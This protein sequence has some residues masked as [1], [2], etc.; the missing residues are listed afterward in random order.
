MS[1]EPVNPYKTVGRFSIKP[2][3][4][5]LTEKRQV[6]VESIGLALVGASAIAFL[7][8]R[9]FIPILVLSVLGFGM[10]CKSFLLEIENDFLSR[11]VNALYLSPF[12]YLLTSY[13]VVFSDQR[14]TTEDALRTLTYVFLVITITEFVCMLIGFRRITFPKLLVFLQI[15]ATNCVCYTWTCQNAWTENGQV[16]TC[17]RP[18]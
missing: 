14:S 10:Y 11:F 3:S 13:C 1:K 16:V 7:I 18:F 2:A 4:P 9:D 12:V 5:P 8:E 6:V 17:Y 15:F